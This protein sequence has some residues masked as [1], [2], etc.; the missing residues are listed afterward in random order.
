M[1]IYDELLSIERRYNMYQLGNN[2]AITLAKPLIAKFNAIALH[3]H[4]GIGKVTRI[5]LSRFSFGR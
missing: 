5:K 4:I 1:T 2:E 3:K